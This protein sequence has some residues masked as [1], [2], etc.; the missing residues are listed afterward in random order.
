MKRA[1]YMSGFVISVALAAAGC[2]SGPS[3]AAPTSLAPAVLTVTG[4]VVVAGH[5]WHQDAIAG[6]EC[7]AVDGY[8][9]IAPGMQLVL[10][11]DAGATLATAQLS[12]GTF[13]KTSEGSDEFSQEAPCSFPFAFAAVADVD[14]FYTVAVGRRGDLKYSRDQLSKPLTLTM[15]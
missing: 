14:G 11:D 13:T 1:V 12:D 2:A 7:S 5:T 10:S 3:A 8:G 6:N 15:G 4:V 9:D